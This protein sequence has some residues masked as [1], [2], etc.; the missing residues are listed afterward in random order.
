MDEIT[1]LIAQVLTD[2]E[3]EQNKADEK[4]RTDQALC[5]ETIGGFVKQIGEQTETISSLEKSIEENT[6][7]LQ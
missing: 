6:N 7:I 2:L 4:N 5:D 1:L 3:N